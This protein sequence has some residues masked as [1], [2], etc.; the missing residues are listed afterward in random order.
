MKK[1]I[2]L[3]FLLITPFTIVGQCF[4][5]VGGGEGNVIAQKSDGTVWFWGW[6]ANGQSGTGNNSDHLTPVLF[7]N[8][9]QPWTTFDAGYY[10]TF[11]IATN[12]SLWGTGGNNV[13]QLGVGTTTSY[14]S[15]VQINPGTTWKNVSSTAHTLAIQTN[16]TLWGWGQNNSG[17]M[18]NGTC[19]ANQLSP[20]QIGAAT[21]WK[22]VE[23]SNTGASLALKENGTLWGWGDNS[24]RLVAT[25]STLVVNYPTQIGTATDWEYISVGAAHGMGLKTDG[26]LWTWGGGGYGQNGTGSSSNVPQQVGTDT[27]Q[28]IA[29]GFQFS[30]G[31]KSD[32]TL[33][34]WGRNNFGQLGIGN[35]TNQSAP[36]Q[37]GIDTNWVA[38]TGGGYHSVGLKTDGS[39]WSWGY[40]EFGQYGNGTTTESPIPLYVPVAGCTLSVSDYQQISL[41]LSPNPATDTVRLSL[42]SG[43]DNV[44]VSVYDLHG[45]AVMAPMYSNG[46]LSLDLSLS[47]LSAGVYV[48]EVVQEGKVIGVQKLVKE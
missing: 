32:G 24:G 4:V 25:P 9:N 40:N 37:I 19:C 46:L 8:L 27:W 38:V 7:A 43:L 34:V 29:A 3:F 14:N 48:V 42:K 47:L 6:G 26:T 31:I 22:Q 17:Q 20:I 11:A 12:G 45:R 30:L 23:S 16:G 21:D 44:S 2:T 10:T 35:T 1:T 15:P 13:G 36:V 39:L 41:V 18:G 33:W 28:F 5:K